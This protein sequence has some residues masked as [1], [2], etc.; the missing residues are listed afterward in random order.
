[1]IETGQTNSQYYPKKQKG[2]LETGK[3]TKMNKTAK[4]GLIYLHDYYY[5]SATS[6]NCHYDGGKYEEC[7]TGGWMHM[8]N[9]T[10]EWTMTRKGR[11]SSSDNT[12]YAWCVDWVGSAS[13]GYDLHNTFAVRPVFY[14]TPDITLVGEGT[15]KNPF[16]IAK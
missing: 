6:N 13:G 15:T 3:W 5:Q 10:N 8:R 4:I 12:F 14:L 1:M 16:Y 7:M 2:S 9:Q 11:W